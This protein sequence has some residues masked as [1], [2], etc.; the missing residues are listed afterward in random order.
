MLLGLF[1]LALKYLY[2]LLVLSLHVFLHSEQVVLP[3]L[4][5]LVVLLDFPDDEHWR[6]VLGVVKLILSELHF[7]FVEHH[8]PLL[9]VVSLFV[10]NHTAISVRD[11]CDDE[12]HEDHKQEYN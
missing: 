11:N 2:R 3:V 5:D 1:G 8:Q 4:F 10:L 6:K 12:V 7:S 9:V